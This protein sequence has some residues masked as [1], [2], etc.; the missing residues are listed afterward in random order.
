MTDRTSGNGELWTAVW[1][2]AIQRPSQN[3]WFPNWSEKGFERAS[4]RQVVRVSAGGSHLRI[5]LSNTFGDGTLRLTRASVARTREGAELVPDTLRPLTFQGAPGADVPAGER[6]A[7]DPVPLA[8]RPFERLTVTLYFEAATGPATF[9]DLA[10]SESYLADGDHYHDAQAAAFSQQ[11]SSWYFLE[12]VEATGAGGAVVTFGDSLTDGYGASPDADN[13]YPDVLARRLAAAGRTRSVLN[14]GI[15]GNRV[16][17]DSPCFGERATVRFGRDVLGRAG[18]T[19]AI[20]LVGINDILFSEWQPTA[21][22]VPQPR[23]EAQE[24]IDGHRALI[25]AA[26]TAGVTVVGATL[27]PFAGAEGHTVR[28]EAVREEFNAWIRNG[29]EYDTVADMAH[30]LTDPSR[31]GHLHPGYDSGDHL[32]PNPAGYRAMAGA[33]DL[34]RL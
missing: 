17:N 16:H 30:A 18:V 2:T 12:A 27:A 14:A 25:R 19:T 31:P 10:M 1:A 11:S 26:R 21:D 4:V 28:G 22:A 3:P 33:V 6:V 24:L 9:H 13:R 34:T 7:S 15:A 29:G 20:V 5:R 32:H 23:I 8:V